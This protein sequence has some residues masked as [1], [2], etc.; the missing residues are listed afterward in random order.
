[1]KNIINSNE[2]KIID[3]YTMNEIG[4]S[5]AVLMER[6]AMA[7]VSHILEL[8]PSKILVVSGRGNNGADGLAI[9]RILTEYGISV[10]FYQVEGRLSKECEHQI[11][12]LE[13]MGITISHE[14]QYL[15]YDIVVDALFGVGI[16]REPDGIYRECISFMN[17]CKNKG[18]VIFSVDIASGICADTGKAMGMAVVAD[19]TVTF[20][21]EKVGHLLYPGKYNTGKLFVEKIGFVKPPYW[22][23]THFSYDFDSLNHLPERAPWG[24]KGTFGKATLFAGNENMCGACSLCGRAIL[25]TGTGMLKIVTAK[26]N[27]EVLKLVFPEAMLDINVMPSDT[28][29]DVI[30]CGPGLGISDDAKENLRYIFENTKQPLVLDADALNCIAEDSDLRN[31]LIV[32]NEENEGNCIITPHPGELLRLTKSHRNLYETNRE[33]LIWKLAKELKCVVVSKDAVTLCVDGYSDKPVYINHSGNDGMATAGSGDVL[34]GIITGLLCRGLA[35]FESAT[36]GVYLHG[37]C[38]DSAVKISG[39]NGLLA[40]DI[41]EQMHLFLE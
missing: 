34:T 13:H 1:M 10:D 19:Y 36:Y 32:R 9:G 33:E 39:K 20:G 35:V 27:Q 37:L 14:I 40:G 29:S 28:W 5:A 16:N 3:N 21:Y 17:D 30:A 2:A 11:I 31:A 26:E 38:G 15:S 22:K 41:I 24:H 6:A 23:E 18:A 25:K 8:N 7:T 4:I 12:I